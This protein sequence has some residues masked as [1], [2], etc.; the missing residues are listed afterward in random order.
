VQYVTEFIFPVIDTG[1]GKL[2]GESSLRGGKNTKH[3]ETNT[4]TYHVSFYLEPD[5]GVPGAIVIKNGDRNEF[6]L[7]FV[8]VEGEDG[9]NIYFNCNSWV[10]PVKKTNK[11][12]LFFSNTVSYARLEN[13]EVK[14][15]R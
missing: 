14:L 13:L 4:I 9:Q 12:R 1:K 11:D 5:F 7:R 6:F 10:Y 15:L 2:S 3:G 8:T